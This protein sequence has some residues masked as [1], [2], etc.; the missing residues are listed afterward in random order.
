MGGIVTTSK[1]NVYHFTT[2]D[3][4]FS[5][6]QNQQ[7][8]MTNVDY[9]NDPVENKLLKRK[10]VDVFRNEPYFEDYNLERYLEIVEKVNMFLFTASFTKKLDSIP[11]WA[12]YAKNGVAIEFEVSDL[13][14][15]ETDSKDAVF[16]GDIRYL[17]EIEI[18]DRVD[19]VVK[20]FKNDNPHEGKKESELVTELMNYT[21]SLIHE[22]LGYKHMDFIYEDEYRIGFK[23]TPTEKFTQKEIRFRHNGS[24]VKPYI[25]CSFK[26]LG[27]KVKSINIS[28]AAG[29]MDETLKPAFELLLAD[30]VYKG[31]SSPMD[32]IQVELINTKIR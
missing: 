17:T 6:L 11:L 4:A 25:T 9:L 18:S 27:L 5:I 3:A 2:F 30:L 32:Q 16:A 22:A 15:L 10:F 31:K 26:E 13:S 19:S 21:H 7:L 24:M 14:L 1:D 8:W 12:N 29:S 28:E 20:A 23:N